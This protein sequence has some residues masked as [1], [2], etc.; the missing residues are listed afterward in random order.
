[1]KKILTALT[2][3]IL[4]LFA[5][6]ISSSA[7][8]VIPGDLD[9]NGKVSMSDVRHILRS[10]ARLET[11]TDTK[12]LVAADV[13]S[14]GKITV[15]DARTA[16]RIAA[17][18]EQ[19]SAYESH[20]VEIEPGTPSD[21][22]HDGTTDKAV[23]KDCGKVLVD[24]KKIPASH[25][26]VVELGLSGTCGSD[27]V[28][29]YEYCSVCGKVIK[30]RTVLPKVDHQLGSDGVHCKWCNKILYVYDD[31]KTYCSGKYKMSGTMTIDGES[32]RSI[33][34]QSGTNSRTRTITADSDVTILCRN[35]D[36]DPKVYLAEESHK[37][38]AELDYESAYYLDLES[39]F[40]YTDGVIDPY[41][42]NM[43]I[44]VGSEGYHGKNCIVYYVHVNNS[45]YGSKFAFYNGKLVGIRN[46]EYSHCLSD[47]V[48]DEFSGNVPND[49]W[50]LTGYKCLD[51]ETFLDRVD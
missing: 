8:V 3:S 44:E 7:V 41:S 20:D 13:N 10:A 21:C 29:D 6:V 14:D 46:Y 4:M 5:L 26:V 2:I 22:E 25:Q 51:L 23:C 49:V 28:S 9:M 50:Y 43:D 38:Y 42:A 12:S 27:G 15:S 1:M 37:I 32:F 24:H 33:T 17:R 18:L 48:L 39:L 35:L 30:P 47:Y 40:Y 45:Q 19:G 34:Y 11:I 16:L 31:F 36:T